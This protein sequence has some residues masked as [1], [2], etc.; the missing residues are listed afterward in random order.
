MPYIKSSPFW[1]PT[2]ACYVQVTAF[3]AVD[4]PFVD[5]DWLSPQSNRLLS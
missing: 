5:M 3:K 1:K 4:Q 2:G